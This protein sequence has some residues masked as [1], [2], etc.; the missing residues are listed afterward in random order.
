[1]AHSVQISAVLLPS[2]PAPDVKMSAHS[3]TSNLKKVKRCSP[4]TFALAVLRVVEGPGAVHRPVGVLDELARE[5]DEHGVVAHG[6]AGVAQEVRLGAD[7]RRG[8]EHD[9]RV[10]V[11][12]RRLTAVHG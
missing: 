3:R 5:V 2:A 4:R 6:V 12:T 7:R 10:V 1:M 11:E 9:V 8:A